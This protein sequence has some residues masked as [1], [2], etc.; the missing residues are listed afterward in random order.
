MN[1]QIHCIT[2]EGETAWNEWEN[3]DSDFF[4]LYSVHIKKL[5]QFFSHILLPI[6]SS[7]ASYKCFKKL[8][9]DI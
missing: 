5:R 6:H 4:E 2:Y 1:E 3:D 9:S 7:V 8:I